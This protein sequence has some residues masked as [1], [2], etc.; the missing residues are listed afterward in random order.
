MENINIGKRL[1]IVRHARGLTIEDVCIRLDRHTYARMETGK[2]DVKFTDLLKICDILQ[3]N[4]RDLV[5]EEL[6]IKYQ[7]EIKLPI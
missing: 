6:S 5:A 4:V 3:I 7:E 2:M 1:S